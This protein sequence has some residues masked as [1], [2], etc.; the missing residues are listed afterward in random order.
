MPGGNHCRVRAGAVEAAA[1]VHH[2]LTSSSRTC[3]SEAAPPRRYHCGTCQPPPQTS[4]ELQNIF[5]S[6]DTVAAPIFFFEL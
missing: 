4:T 5:H 3:D 2:P 1:L 6:W